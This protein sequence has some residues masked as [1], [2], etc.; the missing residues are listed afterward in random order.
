[1]PPGAQTGKRQNVAEPAVRGYRRFAP[2]PQRHRSGS[3][4]KLMWIIGCSFLLCSCAT[5]RSSF[6]RHMM[7]RDCCPA[8][9]H[10]V[11]KKLDEVV[12]IF[13]A[14]FER[15]QRAGATTRD[16]RRDLL[17]YS[18]R[19]FPEDRRGMLAPLFSLGAL[20]P[21][22]E[23]QYWAMVCMLEYLNARCDVEK[24]CEHPNPTVRSTATRLLKEYDESM[25]K[26]ERQP[27]QQGGGYSPPATRSAQPT[28]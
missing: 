5:T 4:M 9:Y 24:Y 7:S 15:L 25:R 8:T 22:P 6:H 1:V 21:D 13:I 16:I 26:K 18:G 3:T 10:L 12:A 2:Q 11:E 19:N 28:P 20:D 27:E 14:E 17:S 23:I